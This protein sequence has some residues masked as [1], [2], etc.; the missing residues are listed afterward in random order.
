M[1]TQTL[2]T[3]SI[4]QKEPDPMRYFV[5]GSSDPEMEEIERVLKEQGLPYGYA[6]IHGSR[7]RADTA[8]AATDVSGGVLP[9]G[10]DIVF[11]ECSVMGVRY[12]DLIDHHRP[13][14]PG[15]DA[16]A[17]RYLDG[18]SLGQLLAMLGLEPTETQRI[19]A[20][21]DH[22]PT[23]AYQGLCPGVAPSMLATWRT[24]TRAARRGVT[25]EEME[26]A[27]ERARQAML[28][29][30]KIPVAGVDIAWL[31]N[32]EGEFAEASA[33]Y[34]LPYMYWDDQYDRRRKFGIMGGSPEVISC[35][36]REC[37]L[38]DVYGNP[39]RGY[40]G[41]YCRAK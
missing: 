38:S 7:V 37:G 32:A 36:M 30:E 5:L 15:Y 16:P 8:Y 23:Q 18:S 19:I 17:E 28:A 4:T 1:T 2:P 13:G 12:A 35:W 39:T 20:A 6:L 21:A 25:I 3:P 41:G 27:I 40:A 10:I 14:D 34:G 22:C 9:P 31:E 11:I 26:A 29:A 33:R 24:A